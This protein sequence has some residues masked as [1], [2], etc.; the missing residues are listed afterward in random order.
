MQHVADRPRAMRYEMSAPMLY[1]CLGEDAWRRGRTENVSRNGVLF[2]A[3]L[4]VLPARTRI[5]FVLKLPDGGPPGGSWVQ[6]E[7]Q[8]VRHGSA[9]SEGACTMAAT[10]DAYDFLGV[11]P[12]GL[13]V[14]AE[15]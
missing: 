12:D 13:P 4:P 14:D 3:A 2:Q 11:T 1:R 9:G 6:C 15:L 7:G 8:V 10:I 5:E